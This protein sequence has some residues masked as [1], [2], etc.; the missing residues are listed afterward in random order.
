MRSI[1]RVGVAAPAHDVQHRAEDLALRGRRRAPISNATGAT[2]RAAGAV[3]RGR[4]FADAA[5]ASRLQPL[6]RAASSV[7]VRLGVDHRADVG[8]EAAPGR[9]PPARP[10]R[11][12]S[13]S[14]TRVGDASCTHSRR[15]AEQRWPAERNALCT[16]ASTTCSGSAVGSTII[17]LMPPV[18]AI[19][20]TIAPVA[21]GQARG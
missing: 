16:T 7:G 6:R 14:I 11:R 18:S 3:G 19:S 1:T 8:R 17:A 9:R 4:R 15:S 5:C 2:K 10:A 20:G 21:R 12:A 13:I